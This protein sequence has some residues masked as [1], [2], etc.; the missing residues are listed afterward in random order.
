MTKLHHHQT[1]PFAHPPQHP[2][3][4]FFSTTTP[5]PTINLVTQTQNT[6]TSPKRSSS[7]VYTPILKSGL[8]GG[9]AGC[10]AKTLVSP[11]DRVKILFQTGHPHFTKYSGSFTGVFGAMIEIWKTFGIK[12]LVQGH[13]ATLLRIFPYAGI[14]F[15]AY[16]T[17]HRVLIPSHRPES[18][19]R[20]FLAGAMSGVTAV[21]VTY[22]LEVLRVR[23]AFETREA[24][25]GRVRVWETIQSIYREPAQHA[26]VGT[27]RC[28]TQ[29]LFD[30]VPV[31]KFYRG[32]TPT[33][34]G[35]VPYT[36]TSFLVWGTLQ[37]K[38]PP[39]SNH[40][41][42]LNLLCGSIA[43]MVSQ[44]ASYPFEIVR[45]KMQVAGLGRSPVLTMAQ[46]ARSIM[47]RDGLRGF[48]VG[49]SIGYIKVIPMTAI[50]F[51]TWSHLKIRFD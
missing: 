3:R 19:V 50:S 9:I 18:P 28:M 26:Q 45:R 44:T 37:A 22:P 5:S 21:F 29:A 47:A 34:C 39:T 35:M 40:G 4:L 30:K 10:V 46:V 32:F 13:S 20:L 43:G 33:L 16:D 11:L 41:T 48:F 14:K 12:G 24:S 36:G 23:L 15:M 7:D 8:A 38:L 51:V 42:V 31:A 17:F 27:P 49:L 25:A 1:T 6:S 2:L